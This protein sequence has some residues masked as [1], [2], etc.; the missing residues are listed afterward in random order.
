M[1]WGYADGGEVDDDIYHAVRLARDVGGATNE[2]PQVMMTDANGVQYD[3]TGKVVQPVEGSDKSSSMAQPQAEPENINKM[4]NVAP[5]NYYSD[6]QPLI[7][8]AVTPID[9]EGM[10][11][12]PDL[13]DIMKVA[14]QV[15]VE[16]QPQPDSRGEANWSRRRE[17]AVNNLYGADPE[18]PNSPSSSG[19]WIAN[20]VM[21]FS[22]TALGEIAHDFPYEAVRTG[23]YGSAAAEAGLNALMTAPVIGGVARGVKKGYDYLKK[24]PAITSGIAG[25]AGLTAGS[26]EAE[27]GPARW[28]SKAMEVAGALPMEKMTGQQ[29]LA[30]L[31]KNVSPEELRWTGTEKFLGSRP[32]VSK[33]ELLEHLKNNRLQLNEI[34]LESG[35][36]SSRDKV[37]ADPDLQDKYRPE[38]DRVKG[39][40][41]AL[42]ARMKA[43]ED[44]N[45]I[46]E[47]QQASSAKY[48]EIHD[49]TNK[50]IDEQ[51]ER[52][53]GLGRAPKYEQYSTPG[54]EGYR[55][56]LYSFGDPNPFNVVER[57]GKWLIVDGSGNPQLN[58]SG[59]E[60]WY[61]DKWDAES[62]AKSL[63][64]GSGMYT[65]PHWDDPNVLWH[66]RSQTLAYDPPGANRPYRVHNVDETQ[67]DPGQAGRRRGFYDPE[68]AKEADGY[69]A[70]RVRL[71]NELTKR[72]NEIRDGREAALSPFHKEDAMKREELRNQYRNGQIPMSEYNKAL[73][74]LDT[75]YFEK[76]ADIRAKFGLE[77]RALDEVRKKIEEFNNLYR[78]TMPPRDGIPKMPFVTSTEAWTDRS[79][80]QELDKALDSGADYFSW[81][82]GKVHVDRYNLRNHISEVQYNP[83]DKNFVAISS[84]DGT[85]VMDR[86]IN[87][88]N[89]I[90]E[91]IGKELADRL[92]E[93][94][95]K[96]EADVRSKYRV[97]R[98]FEDDYLILDKNNNIVR[99]NNNVELYDTSENRSYDKLESV[100]QEE[101]REN[102][103]TLGGIDLETGG[104]GMM[105]YYDKVYLKRVQKVLE[106][107]TGVKMPLEEIEVQTG[108]G[109]R[110]QL[111]V[112]LTDEMREKARFSDFNRGGTVTAP[113]SYG[114]D[115]HAVSRAIALTREY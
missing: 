109:P 55:E 26:D 115:D 47:L 2:N 7:D 61:Y 33:G 8:Y 53:G 64:R 10:P 35:K 3:A 86:S 36:V 24:S 79:I 58:A 5:Q 9:R 113:S 38:F 28:F 104:E 70:E 73:D 105:G 68:K 71:E 14:T 51:I 60:R 15:A 96:H 92:R 18:R 108:N 81:S 54:G 82:P 32:Q 46:K 74:A 103:F 94:A 42:N 43:S 84:K 112:K 27:A 21:D 57:N 45:E 11:S 101:L 44:Y 83:L 22:P 25:S 97:E 100:I 17:E 62:A 12:E 48:R 49:I 95:K 106:K 16:G 34:K 91:I 78:E 87:D 63:Y 90:D 75:E 23:D 59:G 39:E 30:M 67:S 50:M 99:D 65:S 114:N 13:V 31:R 4:F 72:S 93:G 66:T 98:N 56:S 6:V 40:Y 85:P 37:V 41:D 1:P 76:T 77:D 89:E 88:P 102:P 69:R 29:A 19:A 52:M 80:K 20:R 111:G 110:K 107:A